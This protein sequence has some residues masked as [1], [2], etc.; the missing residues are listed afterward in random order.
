VLTAADAGALGAC[1]AAGGVAVFPTDTVYGLCCD[2][3]DERAVARL[4]ELKGRPR[5]RAAAVMFFALDAA[6]ETL[7]E[8]DGAQRE[9]AVRLLPGPVTVLLDNPRR[10]WAAGC[11]GDPGTLGLR[12]P[13]LPPPLA[14]LAGLRGPVLQSSANLSGGG[15]ARRV[16]E[17]DASVVDGADLVLDG[18]VL[19]GVASTVVDLR[20]EAGAAGGYRVQ[21][22][23][24]L[25]ADD[26][27]RLLQGGAG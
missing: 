25:A 13:A 20:G 21:R 15:D 1:L 11:G 9:A 8:I 10:R 18:G 24:A 26:V 16:A 12:V 14:A 2:P 4:Y 3:D 17:I 6:L 23:G 5:G 7:E 27:Q 22:E 19:P